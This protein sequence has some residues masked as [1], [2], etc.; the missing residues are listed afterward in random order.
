VY[1]PGIDPDD[2]V[3]FVLLDYAVD[4]RRVVRRCLVDVAPVDLDDLVDLVDEPPG[5]ALFLDDLGIVN[6]DPLGVRVVFDVEDD[7][8][9]DVRPRRSITPS[10]YGGEFGTVVRSP[11]STISVT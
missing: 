2:E 6:D 1:L 8:R 10:M 9:I 7:L 11:T 4:R 5:C 3:V